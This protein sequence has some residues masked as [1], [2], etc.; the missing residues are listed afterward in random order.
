MPDYETIG[1]L[2]IEP[3]C[4]MVTPRGNSDEPISHYV[5]ANLTEITARCGLEVLESAHVC[6]SA[7]IV[8]LTRS[9][10]PGTAS[11]DRG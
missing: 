6:R 3:L 2:A 9:A 10:E 8:S 11:S 1:W 4:D 7:L 5:L